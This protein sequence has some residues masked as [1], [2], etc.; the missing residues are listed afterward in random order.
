MLTA[1]MPASAGQDIS[2]FRS[3]AG[4]TQSQLAAKAG[5]D[6]SRVSRIEKGEPGTPA[7]FG[8]LVDALAALGSKGA[9][10]YATFLG[11]SWEHVERPDFTN[12]QRN[13]LEL[14]EEQ[15]RQIASFL[16]EEERPWPLKRQLERQHAAI[17]ASAVYLGKTDHQLAFIGEK[18]VGKS[19]A[20]SFLFGLLDPSSSKNGMREHVV[21][22]SGGGNTTLCE[23]NIRR[24][25]SFGIVVQAQSDEEVRR[26]VSDF[27][28]A[29]MSHGVAG[30][31]QKNDSFSPG[32]EVL[33]ALRWMSDL[34]IERVRDAQ[35]KTS[36]RD[37]AV[38]L[39][40]QCA[41]EEEFRARVIERM[42][43]ERRTRREIWIEEASAKT[44]MQQLKKLFRDIN[45]GRLADV[46]MP[47]SIDML[48]P[49]FGS[50]VA[51][52]SLSAVDTKGLGEIAVRADLDA[53]LKDNRT[54]VVLCSAFNQAPS[55]SVQLL[56]DHLRNAHG[57]QVDAGKVSVLALPFDEQAMAVN[58]GDGAPP[59]DDEDG[60][61]LKRAEIERK[62]AG[63]DD[64]MSG[65]PILFFN[66]K[67]DDPA[68][69]RH[70]LF[71]QVGQLRTSYEQRLRA[72]C[73]AAAEIIRNHKM[74]EF[75][76]AVQA[77]ADQLGH[78]L[79]AH[80][81]LPVRVR[82]PA[83][84]LV[85][86]LASISGRGSG[87][88]V[89]AMTRRNGEYY[90][91]SV[92]HQVGAGGAKDA[93]L[94]SKSWFD[95]LQVTLDNLKQ[96]GDLVLAQKTIQQVEASAAGWRR[97]FAEAA[98]T[99]T[100]EIYREALSDDEELWSRCYSAWGAD[101]GGVRFKDW[102]NNE[103][104]AWFDERPELVQQLEEALSRLWKEIVV[105]PLE[106]L[107]DE[108]AGELPDDIRAANVIPFARPV[109]A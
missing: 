57:V 28:A 109:S 1:Q 27:C 68:K 103:L 107:S 72:E 41:T 21:L 39:A 81:G 56:L 59:I 104:V 80:M 74:Q 17:Q 43:L 4:V 18:G 90:N 102:V 36:S 88:T 55:V 51:G 61:D 91:F 14:A 32:E 77:V 108:S 95:G 93:L 100:V 75:T 71:E 105:L 106:R 63:G 8:K 26:L 70:K 99:A 65:L 9:A 6:Q 64:L 92:S 89:W 44:A 49:G 11:K 13:I 33:R 79:R 52:L 23:V 29:I 35:G 10:D 73:D 62:L 48:I 84:E 54:H 2:L 37:P 82:Q 47:S 25:P 50:D 60:Y 7:E 101:R 24:G 22:E 58:T 16:D 5:L 31:G 85:D 38:E 98:R 76:S 94:R 67:K 66:A 12:P 86:A 46:P 34:K 30:D 53:R 87:S 83:R 42:K 15:L 3:E 78:F 97:A 96:D 20:I 40:A 69:I 19:T 45:N